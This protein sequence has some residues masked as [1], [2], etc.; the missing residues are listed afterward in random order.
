MA[1]LTAHMIAEEIAQEVGLT[2]KHGTSSWAKLY[3]GCQELVEIDLNKGS[4]SDKL[5]L[6]VIPILTLRGGQPAY[7]CELEAP[8][9]IEDAIEYLQRML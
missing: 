9:C 2:A 5:K 7:V 8:T 6:W 3:R 4:D 1:D